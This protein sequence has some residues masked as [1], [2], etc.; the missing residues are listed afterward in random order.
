MVVIRLQDPWHVVRGDFSQDKSFPVWCTRQPI[1]S[2][3]LPQ[4][5]EYVPVK[6]FAL[7]LAV[8]P[9]TSTVLPG[10]IVALLPGTAFIDLE[11]AGVAVAAASVVRHNAA[12][13]TS[14]IRDN[15]VRGARYLWGSN[16]GITLGSM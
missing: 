8:L 16:S 3:L 11:N 5:Q 15:G 7:I 1:A 12:T 6:P 2:A 10:G 9:F 13:S 4:M 14:R